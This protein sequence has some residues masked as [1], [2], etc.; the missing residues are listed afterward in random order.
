MDRSTVI[1]EKNGF[2]IIEL[3]LAM[4]FVS[5]LLIA[6]AVLSMNINN[7][8]TRGVTYKELNQAGSEAA[9]DIERTIR[10]ANVS[11][12]RFIDNDQYHRLCLG[13]YSYVWNK[14]GDTNPTRTKI[15][16]ATGPGVRLAKVD[17]SE[18]IYCSNPDSTT[19]VPTGSQTTQ[20][21]SDQGQR[22]LFVYDLTVS[23]LD[24]EDPEDTDRNGIQI[25]PQ[26]IL[27]SRRGLFTIKLT[28][29][30]ADPSQI[31][32][33]SDP[34]CRPPAASENAGDDYCA[35]NVFTTVVLIGNTY[36][37]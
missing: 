5:V 32:L 23:P 1:A 9:D 10:S 17:D 36:V 34:Q 6:V 25:S 24:P 21:L 16:S 31:D 13:D 8:Y 33:A 30:T 22:D 19:V 28:L 11:S 14:I 7:I 3:M 26:A 2:T 12:I 4:S 35:V 15:G 29:G 18:Q 27:D 20:L 37:P